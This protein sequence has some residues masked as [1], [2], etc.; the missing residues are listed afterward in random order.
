MFVRIVIIVLA[1]MILRP[2][3]IAQGGFFQKEMVRKGKHFSFPVFS[4]PSRRHVAKKINRFLQL[5]ELYIIAK[6]PYTHR[7]FE[8]STANDGSI[9]GGKSAIRANVYSNNDRVLSVGFSQES[10]GATCGYWNS[11]YN[12]NSGNGDRIEL[13]ELFEP[14]GYQKF[15]KAVL[16]KRES[17]YRREVRKKVEPAEQ[18]AYLGTLGCFESDDLSDFF[19]RGRS[20]VIDGDSCLAKSQK[21]SGLDMN[22]GIDLKDFHQHLSPYGRAIFGLSSQKVSAYRSTELPQLFEGSV[23]DA[24]P[25]V[26]VLRED[27]W[28]GYAGHYAYLKYGEGLALTGSTVAGEIK[29]KELVLSRDVVINELGEVRKPVQSG[30]VT[31]RLVGNRFVGFWNDISCANTYSFEAS[32]K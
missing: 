14:D 29:L 8:Q 27:S 7:I 18:E 3:A 2:I 15:F 11:Y 6:P 5:S 25:F 30:T 26:M 31:G 23:N 24:F 1:V 10:C 17:K 4:Q 9:Y 21:F 32:A 16:K 22:V 13:T 12:F 19:V 28:G 20:I